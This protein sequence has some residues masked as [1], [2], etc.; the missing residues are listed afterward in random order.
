MGFKEMFLKIGLP[1][2]IITL[3][4]IRSNFSTAFLLFGGVSIVFL[5]IGK[6][7][8]KHLSYLILIA[9]AGLGIIIL[10]GLIKPEV[11]PRAKTWVNRVSAFSMS[12]EKK[13][14]TFR[15]Y[16]L[17]LQLLRVVFWKDARQKYSTYLFTPPCL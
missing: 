12:S 10:I 16:I 5:F 14:L 11:F 4:I 2:F 17:K 3:L 6:V 9:V 8:I 15:L 1:L 13:N 7:K